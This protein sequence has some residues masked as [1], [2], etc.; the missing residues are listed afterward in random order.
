MYHQ[1]LV[2][3][4]GLFHHQRNMAYAKSGSGKRRRVHAATDAVLRYPATGLAD[5]FMP[6]SPSSLREGGLRIEI[7]LKDPKLLFVCLLHVLSIANGIP[8]GRSSTLAGGNARLRPG[9]GVG[10]NTSP[11]PMHPNEA[12]RKQQSLLPMYSKPGSGFRRTPMRGQQIT[13]GNGNF[14][15]AVATRPE[16]EVAPY[17]SKNAVKKLDN[18]MQT[19][20]YPHNNITVPFE[21]AH[22]DLIM[23]ELSK[24]APDKLQKAFVI[25]SVKGLTDL[26]LSSIE[27][28]DGQE[29][30]KSLQRYIRRKGLPCDNLSKHIIAIPTVVTR[31]PC[32]G[33]GEPVTMLGEYEQGGCVGFYA[34]PGG[35]NTGMHEVGH[36]LDAVHTDAKND[37]MNPTGPTVNWSVYDVW[38][39]LLNGAFEHALPTLIEKFPGLRSFFPTG[40][41]ADNLAR[42]RQ[43][44]YENQ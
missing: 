32:H 39:A 37:Y 17:K 2:A 33:G 10:T 43:H 23:D 5:T 36:G 26:P 41:S 25:R 1:Q 42:M 19:F 24:I 27:A 31:M 30:Y 44:I 13:P 12:F 6:P 38:L 14:T 15:T 7:S 16:G 35:A 18:L 8:L 34:V 20:L 3:K 29:P 4:T 22:L 28:C 9:N 40:F 21:E 11:V